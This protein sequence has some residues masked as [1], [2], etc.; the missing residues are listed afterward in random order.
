MELKYANFNS[1]IF[2][3]RKVSPIGLLFRKVLK[4]HIRNEV[5]TLFFMKMLKMYTK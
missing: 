1:E 2:L 5:N 3:A 4:I